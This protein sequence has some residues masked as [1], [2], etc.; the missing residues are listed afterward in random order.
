MSQDL[1]FSWTEFKYSILAY[2]N[3]ARRQM[4][5]NPD[6]SPHPL[7]KAI[8]M[9]I[10]AGIN[11]GNRR[12]G[13]YMG[14]SG[15]ADKHSDNKPRES[16][17]VVINIDN[18]GII[19]ILDIHDLILDCKVS[20]Q[21]II[22][23]LIISIE[24][25][26]ISSN[27]VDIEK[28]IEIVNQTIPEINMVLFDNKDWEKARDF[29]KEKIEN[30]KFKITSEIG[31]AF[32]ETFAGI[33]YNTKWEDYPPQIRSTIGSTWLGEKNFVEGKGNIY[34]TSI[35]SSLP[36]SNFIKNVKEFLIGR[37]SE[38]FKRYLP[39]TDIEIDIE[40]LSQYGMKKDV[41]R[42]DPCPC[43]SGKKYKKCCM[44]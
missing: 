17:A 12:P 25:E 4:K 10:E 13:N 42:N 5:K 14:L 22:Y 38:Y 1:N 37:P 44:N 28:G 26:K 23:L 34:I 3:Y 2:L 40:M 20:L 41:K 31:D 6:Y 15:D 24:F 21:V 8:M 16:Y 27:E 18:T 30:G 36:K 32:I 11:K 33:T 7:I 35:E 43:G 29:L 19:T 39:Y 9:A